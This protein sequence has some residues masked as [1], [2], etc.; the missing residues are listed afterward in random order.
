MKLQKRF[1]LL[2]FSLLLFSFCLLG[3]E[4][5]ALE[6]NPVVRVGLYYGSNALPAANLQNVSGMGSGYR[7]GY[8][9]WPSGRFT[10]LMEIDTVEITIV[11]DK[12]LYISADKT[13]TDVAP[14]NYSSTVGPY[15]LQ[16]SRRFSSWQE[17]LA[18]CQSLSMEAFPAYVDGAYVARIGQYGSSAQAQSAQAAVAAA[19]LAKNPCVRAAIPSQPQAPTTSY[20]SWT[21]AA[22]VWASSPA[23]SIP[24]PGS[25]DINI[26]AALNT[27]GSTETTSL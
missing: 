27:T 20:S 26:T 10:S 19:A 11:K 1:F 7:L 9:D 8:F 6:T 4:S 2:C 12:L 21:A 3:P 16:T 15:H 17:A 24:R 5:R 14:A 18:F 23:G 25:K 13:Y 22:I